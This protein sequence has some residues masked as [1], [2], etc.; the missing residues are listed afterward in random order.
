MAQA[1]DYDTA[2]ACLEEMRADRV[3]PN[4]VTYSTLMA[5]AP[6][7]DTA[8]ACLEEMPGHGVLPNVVTYNTLFKKDLSG[9][10][11]EEILLWYPSQTNHPEGPMG[12]V[13]A[14]FAAPGALTRLSAWF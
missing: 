12:A 5:Q 1:P 11:A 14:S 4:V 7:Y 6:D 10:T 2:R 8:R 9:Q 3:L 13:I